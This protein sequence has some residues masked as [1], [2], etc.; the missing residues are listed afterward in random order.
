[1]LISEFVNYPVSL[2][3]KKTIEAASCQCF[4]GFTALCKLKQFD[5]IFKCSKDSFAEA[6]EPSSCALHYGNSNNDPKSEYAIAALERQF[7][8]DMTKRISRI[9]IP[10]KVY[11]T[12]IFDT[13]CFFK[14]AKYY[15][16]TS[17]DAFS[18]L[19]SRLVLE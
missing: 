10:I 17:Y 6:G 3:P 12:Y 9:A 16:S 11:Y 8:S 4:F 15:F 13:D 19:S 2:P 1:M 5:T 7:L 14:C 18:K